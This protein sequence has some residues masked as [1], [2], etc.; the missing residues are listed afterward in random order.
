MIDRSQRD[1]Y[2]DAVVYQLHTKSFFDSNADGFGD[3]AGLERK[4]DYISYLGVSVIWLLPFYPSPLRDDGYDISDYRNVH[5]NYGTLR[6]FRRFLRA[7][8]ERGV[9][10]LTELVINHTSDQH[11]WFQRARRAKPGSRQRAFYVWSDTN[12]RY[13]GTRIIFLD[14]EISNWAWDS[15][16]N[17]YYWHRFYSHQPDLNYDNPR[18]LRAVLDA[19]HFWLGAGV[20]AMRL[21]A[22]PYLC[23]REGTN[24]ENLPESHAIVKRIRAELDARYPDRMLLAEANQWPEDTQE[25]FGTGDECHM[26]FHFPLMPRMYMAI[27][28]EDR[29]PITDI[30]RQ[31][32]EIPDLCQWAVF[33]RNHDELTLEMVTD[34]ERD[35]LWR[36]YASDP[37][38]RLNLGIRRRLAPL[39]DNDRPKIELMNGLLFSMP[40]TPIIYYGDEI[41]MG[42]NV[43]LGDRD[44]V[45][46]PM[47][48][49]PDRNAGFSRADP[50]RLYLPPIMD[51][52]YGYEAVNVEAQ[53]NDRS[54]L[55]NWM[56]RI[57]AVRQGHR[58]FGRG[59]LRFL[60]PGN[61]KILA[62][63]R[64]HEGETVLCVANLS[65][66]AQPVELDLS[67]FRGRVPVELGGRT[68]FPP[69]GELPYLLTLGGYGFYWFELTEQ[70]AQ[71]TWHEETPQPLPEFV[72]L[73]ARDGWRSLVEG[74]EARALETE[75]LPRYLVNQ[76]WFAGK[77]S[78]I[79]HCRLVELATL[80][81]GGDGYLL[82]VAEATVAG[83]ALSH[84]L[85]LATTWAE[86][87][88]AW[89]S[90]LLPF[91]LAKIRRG[92]KVGAVYDVVADDG[93]ARALI[94]A[95]ADAAVIAGPSASI[96]FTPGARF[97][98]LRVGP[99]TE[100]ARIAKEQTNSSLRIGDQ[101]ILKLYRR[102]QAGTQPEIEM[103]R[104]LTDAVAFDRCAP[105]L[106]CV[107]SVPEG[108]GTATALAVVH[109][110]VANQG[111]GWTYT[112]EYLE[113][114]LEEALQLREAE[115]TDG[116]AERHAGYL[117]VVRTLARR[118]GEMHVALAGARA[119]K[120]FAAAPVGAADLRRWR[121]GT[122][123]QARTA[124]AALRRALK[125]LD[126]DA[127][128]LA[129]RVLAEREAC[130]ERIRDL[131]EG[132]IKAVRCRVH[133]DYHLGQVVLV[134][135][136]FYVLDFEGEPARPFAERRQKTSPLKDVAGMLRSFD[137]AARTS[138]RAVVPP[139]PEAAVR[140]RAL[141][142]AWC[143]LAQSSF[144]DAY[145]QAVAGSGAIPVNGRQAKRLLDLFMIEKALYEVAYEAANRPDWLSV[146]LSGLHRMLGGDDG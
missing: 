3:F 71:P 110:Y 102:L 120:A 1:W 73:V 28:Q 58:A 70:A 144:L 13:E 107:E 118:T 126:D 80:A 81:D 112:V 26:A 62:Y 96:Q 95:L 15:A 35:Y 99:E 54:S 114:W 69:I 140:A 37:R 47:Q 72:T 21:D 119:P 127:R 42:D 74:R 43:F 89:N 85:P 18:V 22:V 30:M 125:R 123:R 36:T 139:A 10:V 83:E 101:A 46:T 131:T 2:K 4:L 52:I 121:A 8:H 7:A 66:A 106:G 31:T 14:T 86:G 23:E 79:E 108:G 67:E 77:A 32:P 88:T 141:V 5:R 92:A 76:R 17:A 128:A 135:E 12:Q 53:E 19:M 44:G 20:D 65:R 124:F 33:L 34:E 100:I 97:A 40:G 146:P 104:Y 16:A 90:P 11:P 82:A 27:A 138:A 132:P 129:A 142:A 133:G 94:A 38:A 117:H 145:R 56:R 116:L 59:R 25:Y 103:G 109:G 78:D 84:F 113:R 45:R 6:D 87:A 93:F 9:R 105:L 61:R 57:I 29:H 64:Q 55:L 50:A 48:W 91:C 63:L 24:N 130:L 39:M 51:P 98:S 136:D 115:T 122:M 134:H 143:E 49:S 60:Y 41:G 111:D 137:Y 75:V 68:A